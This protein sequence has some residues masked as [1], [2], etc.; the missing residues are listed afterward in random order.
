[1]NRLNRIC[2][3]ALLM[4]VFL[5]PAKQDNGKLT[6]VEK[7]I[8][9]ISDRL[10][11]LKKEEKSILNDIYRVELQYER[12]VIENNKIKM[13]VRASQE[14]I[15][16]KN[17]EKA[18]LDSEIAAS[19][20]NL[21]ELIRIL[22]KMGGNTHLKLFSQVDNLDQLFRNYRL[23]AAL[24]DYK[25]E[26]LNKFKRLVGRLNTVRTELQQQHNRLRNLQNQKEQKVRRIRGLKQEK[27][28][29]MRKINSDRER[30]RK[31]LDELENEAARLNKMLYG[32]QIKR[33]FGDIDLT[34]VRGRLKWP[35]KGRVISSF[36]KK[37]STRFN[38]YI[39]NNGIKI[40]PTASDD[41][42]AVYPGEIVFA[43][44][45]KGYGNLVIIQH[46][47]NLYTLYGHCK[48]ILKKVGENVGEGDLISLVGDTGSTIG[49]ALYFE[50][51]THTQPQDPVKWLR[52]N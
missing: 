15:D 30:H 16:T 38:T 19:R 51:R 25:S 34:K 49:K 43:D 17:K 2:V 37:R 12:A 5:Y 40:K 6:G 24:I 28:E 23:F 35:I 39:I 22:Y 14:V 31:H 13:Q 32:K 41:V 20:K 44:Y 9:D 4:S 18:R 10:E 11:K 48:E 45:Y 36:G 50:V 21:G 3:L 29:M 8:Q 42:K 46:S 33:R 47:R 7:Q 52:R 27:L 26:E 1:M